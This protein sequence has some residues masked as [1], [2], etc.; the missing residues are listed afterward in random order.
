MPL[1]RLA[2]SA[3]LAALLAGPL[4]AAPARAQDRDGDLEDWQRRILRALEEAGEPAREG[5]ENYRGSAPDDGAAEAAERARR[6]Y[7]GRVLAVG[8]V[9]EVYRV[10]LLLDT[11][12]VV[13]VEVE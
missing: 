8:R 4:N 7:G 3:L 1:T 5:A 11:G 2:C 9:G 10:R 13:T 6:R 12:R